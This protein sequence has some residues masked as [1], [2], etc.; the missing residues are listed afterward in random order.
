MAGT[1]ARLTG[2]EDGGT[3]W[4]RSAARAEL[5]AEGG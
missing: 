4:S 2:P 1:F 5:I 3:D